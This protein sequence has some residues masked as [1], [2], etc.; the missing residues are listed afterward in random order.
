MN[1]SA[2]SNLPSTSQ[3]VK[4][5]HLQANKSLGQNFIFDENF[6]NKIA[7]CAGN[8][9]DSLILEIGAGPGGL[10]RAILNAGAR[11]VVAIE[12][13]QKCLAALQ[14]LQNFY[15]DRLEI[16]S[17]DAIEF[18]EIGYLQRLKPHQ[19]FTKFRIIANLPYN[20]GTVLLIKWL[21]LADFIESM[22]LMLQKEVVERITAKSGGKNFGRLAVMSNFVCET[23][24][25][26]TVAP[27]VFTPPPKITS[28][29]VSLLPLPIEQRKIADLNFENSF[30]KLEKLAAIAFNQ[31]RKMLKSSLKPIFANCEELLVEAK[32]NPNQRPEG[33]TLAEFVNLA[34][35]LP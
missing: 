30:K 26:F 20:I 18:D 28:A 21:K 32:I 13:D 35:F 9:Q 15:G 27:Q 3:L 34:S 11:K 22:T 12:K 17:G 4:K 2:I 31:R 8:L 25:M 33:L 7:R 23:K 16:I 5:Y 19:K 24:M 10:T 29:I 14:E 1:S 6:T